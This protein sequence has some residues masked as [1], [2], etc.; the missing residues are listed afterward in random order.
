[1][2]RLY[3]RTNE[4]PNAERKVG[5]AHIS[6]QD[7]LRYTRSRVPSVELCMIT[8]PDGVTDV[9]GTSGPL[10]SSTDHDVLLTLR[11]YAD[12]VLVGAGTVRAEQYKAPI[13]SPLPIVVVTRTTDLDFNSALF[14]SGWAMIATTTSAPDTP[15]RSFR[16]GDTEVDL[17]VIIEQLHRELD[18]KIIHVEGGPGLNAA[19]FDADLVDAINI[20]ISPFVGSG[21]QTIASQLQR[22][23]RFQLA[24]MYR[25][26][27]YMFVRYERTTA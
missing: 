14:T 8:T 27:D 1:V 16:A 13:R 22:S 2:Q 7:A 23:H 15:V 25:D 19:L 18:A 21:G 26:D 11:E 17:A 5:D 10:G 4:D 12:V 6:V 9:G 20:T 3:P 24:H